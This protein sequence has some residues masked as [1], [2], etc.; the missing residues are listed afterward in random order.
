MF[1]KTIPSWKLIDFKV[2]IRRPLFYFY[3][4][5]PLMLFTLGALLIWMAVSE[6]SRNIAGRLVSFAFAA[7]FLH[8]SY[9][10]VTFNLKQRSWAAII[11]G[12]IC[13]VSLFVLLAVQ[14]GG[15]KIDDP[16]FLMLAAFIGPVFL[17][18][19]LFG[20]QAINHDQGVS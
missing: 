12:G 17:L 18:W 20:Y 13:L 19:G 4:I 14:L 3:M 5:V 15:E 1:E 6:I 7:E 16:L 8:V 9:S 10:A 11:F 2:N